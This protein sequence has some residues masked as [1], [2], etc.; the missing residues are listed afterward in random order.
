MHVDPPETAPHETVRLDERQDLPVVGERPARQGRQQLEDL[1]PAPQGPAREL[2]DHEGMTRDFFGLEAGG[3]RS[4]AA[5][6]VVDPDGGIGEDQGRGLGLRRRIGASL[7]SVP[8]S[9]ARRRALSRAIRASSP[10][11][12]SAV[13]PLRPVLRSASRSNASSMSSVVLICM[14]YA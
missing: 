8:P 14:D 7:R 13:L 3:E 11:W 5:A 2:A 10:A 9:A 1:A 4:V 12:T 6:Q